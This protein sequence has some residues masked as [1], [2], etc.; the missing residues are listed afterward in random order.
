MV[1]TQFGQHPSSCVLDIQCFCG[2]PCLCK[3]KQIFKGI[4]QAY[5]FLFGSKV[6]LQNPIKNQDKMLLNSF[7]A[8][9]FYLFIYQSNET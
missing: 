7:D 6:F 1:F 2:V 3:A 9:I 8:L 4:S 5:T